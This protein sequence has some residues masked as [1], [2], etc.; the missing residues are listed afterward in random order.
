MT[1][2]WTA[3]AE[4]ALPEYGAVSPVGT[5]ESVDGLVEL[6]GGG[7]Y[8]AQGEDQAPPRFPVDEELRLTVY[9]ETLPALRGLLRG[10][11]GLRGKRGAL[12]RWSDD[13]ERQRATARLRRVPGERELQQLCH[14][15]LKLPF[16]RLTLWRGALTD[17]GADGASPDGRA[18]LCTT[19]GDQ[20]NAVYSAAV[21]TFYVGGNAAVTDAIITVTPTGDI[22]DLTLT[23]AATGHELA[24]GAEIAD[25]TTLALDATVPS[26]L[27]AGADAWADLTLPDGDAAWLRLA[28]GANPVTVAYTGDGPVAVT[29]RFYDLWE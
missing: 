2:R 20:D 19:G 23:N 6:L 26:V 21:L 13:G 9:A 14:Q 7:V 12:E 18:D 25:G 29:V 3:F 10:L 5:G 22:A 27:N 28:P 8:D 15:P 17:G 1:W 11:T 16:R 24:F 4:V